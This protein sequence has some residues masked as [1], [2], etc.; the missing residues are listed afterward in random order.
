MPA[1]NFAKETSQE[2]RETSPVV[3]HLQREVANGLSSTPTISTIV[4]R[5][6]DPYSAICISCSMSSPP[7]H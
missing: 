4:G 7:T 3:E 1:A 2:S 6:M 5:R